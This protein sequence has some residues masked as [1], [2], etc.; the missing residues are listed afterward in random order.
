MVWF[1]KSTI[2]KNCAMRFHCTIERRPRF[3]FGL[4]F[5]CLNPKPKKRPD[6]RRVFFLTRGGTGFQL[7][8]NDAAHRCQFV[9][10]NFP[11]FLRPIFRT[12]FVS[13]I[14]RSIRESP[15]DWMDRSGGHYFAAFFAAFF[16]AAAGIASSNNEDKASLAAA[17]TFTADMAK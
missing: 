10:S 7:S 9:L 11:N 4:E 14:V 15:V 2:L 3:T 6:N 1:L 17:S 12:F 8:G 13:P 16:G 5:G